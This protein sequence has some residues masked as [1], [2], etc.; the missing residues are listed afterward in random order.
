MK[1]MTVKKLIGTGVKFVIAAVVLLFLG[2]KSLDF[3]LFTTPLDKQYLAYLG[4]GLTSGGVIA[5][6]II[7]LWDA[8]TVLKRAISIVMLF[9]CI[10]GELATAGFGLQ[11]DAWQSGGFQMSESDFSTMVIV[12][13]L[14]GF[15]H[16]IALIAY[17]AGDK[18]V[19][20][21]GDQ[22]G[23]GVPNYRDPDY[24]RKPQEAQGRSQ[25]VSF[26]KDT[27][28]TQESPKTKNPSR[29]ENQ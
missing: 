13:Q 5:Y 22:D 19:E 24:R 25:M 15:A 11:I 4:F 16:A 21:F 6:L 17:L 28:F 14:L 23:D 7:F 18:L 8:D 2:F 27:E 1:R 29:G 9:V 12:T 26:A 20:A 3:F 10:L